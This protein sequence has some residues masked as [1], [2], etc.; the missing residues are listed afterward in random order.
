MPGPIVL[1]KSGLRSA[2]LLLAL[3]S[4]MGWLIVRCL[5]HPVALPLYDYVEYWSAGRLCVTGHDPYSRD[6][7]LDLQRQVGW[8]ESRALMMWN[9][10]WTLALVMPFGAAGYAASH[11]LWLLTTVLGLALCV[12]QLSRMYAVGRWQLC[13]GLIVGVTFMPTLVTL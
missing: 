11:M 4:V 5:Q 8:T 2:L 6:E 1:R 9:P 12:Y 7:L 3:F 10:P 13:V